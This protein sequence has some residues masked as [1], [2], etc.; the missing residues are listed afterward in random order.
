[1][2]EFACG[3]TFGALAFTSYG[4]FWMSFAVIF[5]PFFNVSPAYLTDVPE[6]L[7]AIGHYLICTALFS[8]V[9][10]VLGWFVFSTILTVGTIRSS[11]A[12]CGLFL[13]VA[14]TFLT[15]AIGYYRNSDESFI[16]AG[17]YLGLIGSVLAFY[18]AFA[19]VWN[20]ENS[21]FQLPVGEFPWAEHVRQHVGPRSWSRT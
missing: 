3:N 10:H 6:F 16:K 4:G 7:Q 20:V 21:F 13:I 2:W 11:V 14:M 12:L 9:I 15:L 8:L 18:N 1:M 17:G 5:V 19:V